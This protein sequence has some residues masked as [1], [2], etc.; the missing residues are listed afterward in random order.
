MPPLNETIP[1]IFLQLRPKALA[2]F[3]TAAATEHVKWYSTA[4]QEALK[5]S[6]CVTEELLWD[7]AE[8]LV[9]QKDAVLTGRDYIHLALFLPPLYT[10]IRA[11]AQHAVQNDFLLDQ[12]TLSGQIAAA[13]LE[14]LAERSLPNDAKTSV[15]AINLF[16]HHLAEYL[17][18]FNRT[19]YAE[20][21]QTSENISRVLSLVLS[22]TDYGARNAFRDLHAI[23]AQ[24]ICAAENSE[25]LEN[26]LVE[27]EGLYAT[28]QFE[29]IFFI[30]A[31]YHL[32]I[33]YKHSLDALNRLALIEMTASYEQIAAEEGLTN[34]Y[35]DSP[36]LSFYNKLQQL[37][38]K[39]LALAE[40]LNKLF[41]A[42]HK[43]HIYSPH[44]IKLM[45]Q[46]Y[47]ENF[48]PPFTVH[49]TLPTVVFHHNAEMLWQKFSGT[50]PRMSFTY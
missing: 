13:L 41:A 20:L 33:L 31:Y 3:Y 29:K 28:H 38:K 47:Q 4:L 35:P 43:K 17:F 8:Q 50:T 49:A 30:G 16:D 45:R 7:L 39:A 10:F 46:D 32:F 23:Y 2:E 24:M 26:I 5:T 34:P 25:R 22:L 19:T 27:L 1:D 12:A 36:V 9:E 18:A 6:E 14:T 42:E 11:T 15:I 44:D 21:L 48:Y 40:L 37:E